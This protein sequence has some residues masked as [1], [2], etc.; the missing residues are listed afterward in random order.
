MR[1]KSV[2]TKPGV[3]P[4]LSLLAACVILQRCCCRRLRFLNSEAVVQTENFMWFYHSSR[5]LFLQVLSRRLGKPHTVKQH[6][7]VKES[8]MDTGWK[9][10]EVQGLWFQVIRS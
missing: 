7:E 3:G 1:I 6:V 5:V 10:S 4:L 9:E 8:V 2:S